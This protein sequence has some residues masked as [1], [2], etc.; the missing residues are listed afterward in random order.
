M[1]SGPTGSQKDQGVLSVAEPA[2]I[3]VGKPAPEIEL[4]SELSAQGYL[5]P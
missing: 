4:R 2:S 5:K 3:R 1:V